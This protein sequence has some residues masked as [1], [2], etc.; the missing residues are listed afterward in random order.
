MSN[1]LWPHGLQHSR[2]PCPPPSHRVCSNSYPLSRWCNP[3][4]SSSVVPF[5]PVLNLSQHQGLLLSWLFASG[6]Q[7]IEASVS[8][9]H[10]LKV[11]I[12]QNSAFFMS[13]LS[14]LYMTTGKTTALTIWILVSNVMSLVFNMLSRLVIHF[15]PRSKCL[16]ISWLQKKILRI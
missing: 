10:N 11:S 15:F 5:S 8:F 16:L 9:Q 4:I 2:L 3:T 14:H 6:G 1:S 7:S 12:L 13:Q